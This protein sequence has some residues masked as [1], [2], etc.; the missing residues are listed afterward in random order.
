LY[1]DKTIGEKNA[2]STVKDGRG[3]LSSGCIYFDERKSTE[4]R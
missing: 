1:L 4:R 3:V 2:V